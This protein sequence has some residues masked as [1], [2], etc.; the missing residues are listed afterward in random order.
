[1]ERHVLDPEGLAVFKASVRGGVLQPDDPGY[2]SARR[3]WN[4]MIDRRPALIARCLGNADVIASVNFARQT[5]LSLAVRGGGHNVA[6]T[7]TCDGGLMLDLSA[8]RGVR[9]D[10]GARTVRVQGGAL[11]GDVDRETQLFGL[12]T[13]S[14]YVSTTGVAG[15]TLGGGYGGLRRKFGMTCDN[16]VSADVVTADGQLRVAS[17]RENSDLFWALRGGGGNFGVVT[18]FEFKCHPVGPI[19]FMG[20][21]MYAMEDAGAVLRGWRDFMATAPEEV[22]SNVLF[23]SLPPAPVFPEPL[24]GRPILI[25]AAMYAGDAEQGARVLQPLRELAAPLI[26]I[27]SPMPYVVAQS[28]FDPFFPHGV[29]RYYWKAIDLDG[30]GD[31]VIENLVAIAKERPSPHTAMPLWHFGGAMSRVD[32]TATAFW[33]RK[34]PF[35]VS[36]DSIWEQPQDDQRAVAWARNAVATMRAHGAGGEYVNFAGLAEDGDAQ[37]RASYGGNYER[38]VD[39]KRKYDPTNLFRLNVNIPPG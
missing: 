18:S 12:A 32:P 19:V 27:S 17:E 30:M 11:W 33:R 7:S 24:H 2:D 10:P 25:I 31:D 20:A 14:G 39:I 16:L 29:L 9:V 28:A 13:P 23:W 6:G 8:M 21:P 5:G 15:F 22:S 38:L 3:V 1:M 37:V 35:M 34:T 36:F 4:G 26:D